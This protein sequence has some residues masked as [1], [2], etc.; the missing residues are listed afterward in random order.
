MMKRILRLEG[1]GPW[2]A[3]RPEHMIHLEHVSVNNDD[4]NLVTVVVQSNR[5]RLAADEKLKKK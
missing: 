5:A 4:G 1:N 2:I 3:M